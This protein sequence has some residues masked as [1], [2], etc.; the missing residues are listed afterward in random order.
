MTQGQQR[1]RRLDR[2]NWRAHPP[3][4][5]TRMLREPSC[6]MRPQGRQLGFGTNCRGGSRQRILHCRPQANGVPTSLVL[7]CLLHQH[8]C[9]GAICRLREKHH[10]GRGHGAP[11]FFI[12]WTLQVAS[13]HRRTTSPR[14]TQ[15]S[16]SNG[17]L[18]RR[19]D[20]TTNER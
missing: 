6:N 8:N 20:L 19:P 9:A 17:V 3:E 12:S 16:R 18:Q 4:Q 1:Q 10:K 14:R 13:C 5:S 7:R 2:Q 11:A 15:R